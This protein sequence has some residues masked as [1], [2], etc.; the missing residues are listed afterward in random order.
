MD[1]VAEPTDD[2]DHGE[3]AAA[4]LGF[5]RSHPNWTGKPDK[6]VEVLDVAVA[7]AAEFAALT[8]YYYAAF[9]S[10]DELAVDDRESIVVLG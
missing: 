6:K 3:L 2:P 5:F 8:P 10:E 4:A 9:E 7:R 1:V